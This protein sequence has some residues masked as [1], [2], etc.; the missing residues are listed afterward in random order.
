MDDLKTKPEDYSPS[1]ITGLA[2]YYMQ[3]LGREFQCLHT[4][5]EYDILKSRLIDHI[6]KKEFDSITQYIYNDLYNIFQDSAPGSEDFAKLNKVFR[7]TK[8]NKDAIFELLDSLADSLKYEETIREEFLTE[9]ESEYTERRIF[10]SG[11]DYVRRLVIR[12]LKKISPEF[13]CEREADGSYVLLDEGEHKGENKLRSDID[14]I[15]TKLLILKQFIKQFGWCEGLK[16]DDDHGRAYRCKALKPIVEKYSNDWQKAAE[17]IEVGIFSDLEGAKDRTLLRIAEDMEIGKFGSKTRNREDLYVFAIAFEMRWHKQADGEDD[18]RKNLFFDYYTESLIFDV[19][20]NGQWEAGI[21]GYGINYKNF[22]EICY[23]YSIEH[24]VPKDSSKGQITE[25]LQRFQRAKRMINKCKKDKNAVTAD[26]FLEEPQ[27]SFYIRSFYNVI[28]NKDED[29]A[30]AYIVENYACKYETQLDYKYLSEEEPEEI[31]KIF[32]PLSKKK[33]YESLEKQ[34]GNIWMYSDYNFLDSRNEEDQR[35]ISRREKNGEVPERADDFKVEGIYVYT[36]SHKLDNNTS[37]GK[38]EYTK[39]TSDGKKAE[40]KLSNGSYYNNKHHWILTETSSM[41]RDL[42]YSA[43]NRTA[44]YAYQKYCICAKEKSKT[45][46][47][48]LRQQIGSVY[49]EKDISKINELSTLKEIKTRIEEN[50]PMYDKDGHEVVL[51]YKND[52]SLLLFAYDAKIRQ[53]Q[54]SYERIFEDELKPDDKTASDDPDDKT[55]SDK[56]DDKIASD[57]SD[58][59]V[60]RSELM[61]AFF[62]YILLDLDESKDNRQQNALVSFGNFYAYCCKELNETLNKCGFMEVNPKDIFDIMLFFNSY[63]QLC[64]MYREKQA[65]TVGGKKNRTDI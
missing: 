21:S 31:R 52:F 18:I 20:R 58:Y 29:D 12:R 2:D 24:D 38:K 9:L 36:Q 14:S 25:A 28:L 46:S 39:I 48:V 35:E 27:T 50:L 37:E 11:A 30:I 32:E 45:N 4:R 57:E 1:D 5:E 26:D 10:K 63:L 62:R 8:K 42:D 54:K 23:L 33:K 49:Q 22:I 43:A 17:S 15:P 56:S 55:V 34:D 60:N 13:V 16:G 47:F 40:N 64:E 65:Q 51:K 6:E 19:L 53:E 61:I 44:Y 59:I 7:L 41:P 3:K